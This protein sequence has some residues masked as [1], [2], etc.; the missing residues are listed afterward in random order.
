MRA[1]LLAVLLA[2]SAPAQAEFLTG[3]GL[4][5]ALTADDERAIA[6]GIGYVL[7]V[8]DGTKG[9]LHCAPDPQMSQLVAAVIAVLQAA[10][11]ADPAYLTRTADQMFVPFLMQRFP[12]NRGAKEI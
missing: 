4:L 9:V 8:F 11:K 3:R 12:C 1:V 10:D 6:G 2:L 7:G 5:E